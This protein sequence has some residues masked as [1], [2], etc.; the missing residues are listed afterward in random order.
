MLCKF[1]SVVSKMVLN[2]HIFLRNFNILTPLHR[3]HWNKFISLIEIFYQTTVSTVITS[4][5]LA[6]SRMCFLFWTMLC[7]ESVI[8]SVWMFG[9]V[10]LDYLLQISD[11]TSCF[12]ANFG[13]VLLDLLDLLANDLFVTKFNTRSTSKATLFFTFGS[14]NT[15]QFSH[16]WCPH[17][18][19]PNLNHLFTLQT[20]S[21]YAF[22]LLTNIWSSWPSFTSFEEKVVEEKC[23]SYSFFHS[24]YSWW[25]QFDSMSIT[26]KKYTKVF[27]YER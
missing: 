2:I 8:F 24:A 20:V 11:I 3:Q 12:G 26:A 5:Y 27:K 13:T 4:M 9:R 25:W 22:S 1:F 14:K 6:N 7:L 21:S 15:F 17:T 19:P 10:S 16:H 23:F 18:P